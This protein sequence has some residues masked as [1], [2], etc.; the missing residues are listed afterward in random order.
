VRPGD[1]LWAIAKR[2]L[3]DGSRWREIYEANRDV[4]G[5][6]PNVIQVGMTL[7]IPGGTPRAVDT[8]RTAAVAYKQASQGPVPL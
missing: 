8:I 2:E 5:P 3:G 1:S 7:R 4:I 6:D